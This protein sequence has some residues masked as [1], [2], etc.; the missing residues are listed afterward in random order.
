MQSLYRRTTKCLK[1]IA[2]VGKYKLWWL[3]KIIS[4]YSKY[5]LIV[6]NL[7]PG[8]DLM[9]VNFDACVS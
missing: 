1:H 8:T 6:V 7:Q 5:L 3:S 2:E 4:G 9:K